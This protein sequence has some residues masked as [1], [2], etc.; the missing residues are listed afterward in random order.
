MNKAKGFEVPAERLAWEEIDD[1]DD[2]YGQPESS[3]L[4]ELNE[5]HATFGSTLEIHSGFFAR[6]GH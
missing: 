4:W 3:F 5:F 6:R 2:E 1:G